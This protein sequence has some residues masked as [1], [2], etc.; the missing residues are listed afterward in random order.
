MYSSTEL[1]LKYLYYR[2]HASNGKGHGIHSPF[3]YE[4][5]SEILNDQRLYYPFDAIENLRLSLA[6]DKRKIIVDDYGKPSGTGKDRSVAGI[7]RR[8]LSSRKFGQLLFRMVNHYRPKTIIELGTSLGISAAYLASPDPGATLITLE[9]AAEIAGI[10]KENFEKL[11]LRNIR[12]VTG[13]F[14][15]TLGEVIRSAPPADMIFIDGNH[16]K[17]PLMNYFHQFLQKR[18]GDTVFI[19]H[20]IHWSRGM[21]EGWQQIKDLEEVMLTVDLFTAGIVFFRDCFRVKQHFTIR[22]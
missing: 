17:E 18:S 6:K 3:I 22:F 15:D 20:D 5:V 4:F 16:R 21:E 14:H 2:W 9:G 19:L 10:A 1:A 13:N 12:Q 11:G 8:S 7:A